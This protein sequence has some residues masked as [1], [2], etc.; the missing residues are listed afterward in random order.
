MELRRA[1]LSITSEHPDMAYHSHD[2]YK[3]DIEDL[4]FLIGVGVA[5]GIGIVLNHGLPRRFFMN[6]TS[7]QFAHYQ[8]CHNPSI[9]IPIAG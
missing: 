2:I 3:S 5:S 9:P 7:T 4:F 6:S 1:F 8:H